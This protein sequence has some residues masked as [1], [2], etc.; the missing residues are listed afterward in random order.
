MAACTN[1]FCGF[2]RFTSGKV[3]HA[4]SRRSVLE[5]REE[6]RVRLRVPCTRDSAAKNALPPAT[7]VAFPLQ[8]LPAPEVCESRYR[9]EAEGPDGQ[10]GCRTRKGFSATRPQKPPQRRCRPPGYA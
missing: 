6:S 3:P 1:P 8:R 2:P 5:G 7:I 10:A 4:V 9:L